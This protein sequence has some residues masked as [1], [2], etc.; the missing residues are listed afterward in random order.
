[1]SYS[2]YA[3]N[4]KFCSVTQQPLMIIAASRSHSDTTQSVGLLW[5]S[6]QPDAQGPLPDNKQHSLTDKRS[7]PP[8]GFEPAFP[9]QA[10]KQQHSQQTNV[11]APPVGFEPAFPQQASKQPQSH[12][13][14]RA[15][16]AIG[17]YCSRI[18]PHILMY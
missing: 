16:T 3:G 14:D 12:P 7:C 2:K 9:Q 13:F 15:A 10:S 18:S 11:H 17:I 1:M 8:V 4:K 5:M 6:D